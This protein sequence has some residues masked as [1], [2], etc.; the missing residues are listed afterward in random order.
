MRK[1][2]MM[3]EFKKIIWHLISVHF[4]GVP[5]FVKVRIPSDLELRAIG[6]FS[7]IGTSRVPSDWR[8]IAETASI[9]NELVKASLVSPSYKDIFDLVGIP[10]FIIEKNNQFN[11]IEKQFLETPKGPLRKE[12]EVKLALLKMQYQLILPNDFCSE[13]VEYVLGKNR[14][15]IDK[16]SEEILIECYFKHKEFGGRPSD[17]CN[18]E[19]LTPFNRRDI[20][21]NS[22]AIGKKLEESRRNK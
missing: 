4:N 17:Y 20:D 9:Q 21:N 7:L 2:T 10:D 8:K 3:K 14:T 1:S 18:D 22:I 15:N 5:V 6:N 13:I 16:I 11:E 19:T 12:L